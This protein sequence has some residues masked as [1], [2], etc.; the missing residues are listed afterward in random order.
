M[1][2]AHRVLMVAFPNAQMLDITGPL[3]VFSVANGA[4]LA[5]GLPAPYRV[6]L[7]APR[8]GLLM[9]SSGIAIAAGCSVYDAGLEADTLLLSGG[10]GARAVVRDGALVAALGA[11]CARVGRV[12]SICTGAFALAATGALDGRR[13]TTH[14]AHFDEFALAFP[15]VQ[16]DRDALFVSDG[17]FHSSAGIS[18][19]ID[20]ALALVEH[21]LGRRRALEVARELVVFLRRPGGQSQFSAQLAAEVGAHDPDRFGELTRWI[22]ENLDRELSVDML[23][24]RLAMSPRNFARRFMAAMKVAPGRYMQ[25]LRVDAA[26][27]MLT[28]GELPVARIA[29][30]CG[31]AS[32][33]AMRLAFQRHLNVAPVD[34]RARFQRAASGVG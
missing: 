15:R 27:R 17:K 31:F 7:A 33:E 3:D 12:G 4:A 29:E 26:R 11:L 18:A 25:L 8:A 16:I 13:A 23:A 24:G 6:A 1:H 34:F 14:W 10:P 2:Q 28:D 5:E 9:T 20:Y 19:G 32:A 30:R 21:D 22:G